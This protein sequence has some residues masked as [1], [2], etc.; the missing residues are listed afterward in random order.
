PSTDTIEGIMLGYFRFGIP[1]LNFPYVDVRDVVAAHILAGEKE[2]EGRFIACND[3]LPTLAELNQA[4]HGLDPSVPLPM[5]RMPDLMM[6][7]APLFD[8]VNH[9]LM[10]T[11]RIASPEFLATARGHIFN[12]SNARA[13][14]ELGWTQ[15][16]SL[17][18]S[19]RDTMETI[20]EN[21]ARRAA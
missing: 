19:L 6:G 10:G 1:N 21:R 7:V 4:M 12:A 2:C 8:R 9:R 14:R 3:H 11:P 5:M 13:K 18:Q 15:S 20:R 17:E 16:I